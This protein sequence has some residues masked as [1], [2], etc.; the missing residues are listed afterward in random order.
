MSPD[1]WSMQVLLFLDLILTMTL[2]YYLFWG[3]DIDDDDDFGA[4]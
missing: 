1:F 2:L 4:A 3:P